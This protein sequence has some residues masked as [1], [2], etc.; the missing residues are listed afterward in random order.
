MGHKENIANQS[1][2][3]TIEQVILAMLAVEFPFVES[4]L[5]EVW[6]LMFLFTSLLYFRYFGDDVQKG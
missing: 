3:C 6:S 2:A 5:E 4:F 1:D